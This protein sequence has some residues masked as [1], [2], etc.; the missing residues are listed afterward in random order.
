VYCN[1]TKPS[2]KADS[3]L[4]ENFE[5]FKVGILPFTS[6]ASSIGNTHLGCGKLD[7]LKFELGV[8]PYPIFVCEENGNKHL[9]VLLQKGEIRPVT[10][11]QWNTHLDSS[12][13]E[14]TLSYR[15][16]FDSA[17]VFKPGKFPGIS[18][19]YHMYGVKPNGHD[20][21]SASLMYWQGGR[22]SLYVYHPDQKINFG[23]IIF[24]TP[25]SSNFC[26][27]VNRW[28]N[29]SLHV[30]VNDVGKSNGVVF[31]S[32]DGKVV[33][34]KERIRFRDVANIRF[35]EM[36]FSVFANEIPPQNDEYMYFDDI[37]L[38]TN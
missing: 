22:L 23:D 30:K 15:V 38:T 2:L 1:K 10:G 26:F 27:A 36:Y 34:R 17:F 8:T 5:Q 29:V 21:F 13:S 37:K 16:K 3:L 14:L 25:D 28:Y 7:W 19:G 9:R 32:V 12:Y 31:A 6:L 35:D 11:S 18:G 24:D 20:G 4:F 33:L